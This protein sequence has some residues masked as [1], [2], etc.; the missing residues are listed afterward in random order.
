MADDD[1]TPSPDELEWTDEPPNPG[2]D[3]TPNPE[4]LDWSDTRPDE[5]EP[6]EQAGEEPPAA[7]RP[8]KPQAPISSGAEEPEEQ[9]AETGKTDILNL[10]SNVVSGAAKGFA[11]GIQEGSQVEPETPEEQQFRLK[12]PWI[13]GAVDLLNPGP[14]IRGVMGGIGGAIQG[15]VQAGAESLGATPGEAE[16]GAKEMTDLAMTFA[17]MHS[18]GIPHPPSPGGITKVDTIGSGDPAIRAA[19]AGEQPSPGPMVKEGPSTPPNQQAAEARQGGI[20]EPAN[21]NIP[22]ATAPAPAPLAETPSTGAVHPMNDLERTTAETQPAANENVPPRTEPA[23]TAGERVGQEIE[24]RENPENL[25]PFEPKSEK[26]GEGEVAGQNENEPAMTAGERLAQELEWKDNPEGLEEFKPKK[27]APDFDAE[28]ADIRKQ[29]ETAKGKERKALQEQLAA[30][31]NERDS[32]ALREAMPQRGRTGRPR[33]GG[34]RGGPEE[35]EGA[36]AMARNRMGKGKSPEDILKQIEEGGE[37]EKLEKANG[38]PKKNL[39]PPNLPTADAKWGEVP[40]KARWAL[41]KWF[42]KSPVGRLFVGEG[43]PEGEIASHDIRKFGR[44]YR[45]HDSIDHAL[46]GAEDVIG[47]LPTEAQREI[48]TFIDGTT[49]GS[50]INSMP[51]LQEH[52][53]AIRSQH[54]R[55]NDLVKQYGTMDLGDFDR[56]QWPRQFKDPEAAREYLDEW[57]AGGKT[58]DKR[59][60]TSNPRQDKTP[61][62][63]EMLDEGHELKNDNPI[64]ALRE[65]NRALYDKLALS[66]IIQAGKDRELIKDKPQEGWT[67]LKAKGLEG[68]TLYAP[69]GYASVFNRN[70]SPSLNDTA[71]GRALFKPLQKVGQLSTSINLGL[72]PFHF[73]TMMQERMVNQV[74]RALQG[75]SPLQTAASI[76]KILAGQGKQLME[77]WLDRGTHPELTKFIDKLEDIGAK[78]LGRHPELEMATEGEQAKWRYGT[79]TAAAKSGFRAVPDSWDRI[80]RDLKA[81]KEDIKLSDGALGK[82]RTIAAKTL[83]GVGE[84]MHLLTEPLFGVIIPR[85]K[86][87]SFHENLGRW[88]EKNPGYTDAQATKA[89]HEIWKDVESRF[90]LMNHDNLWIDRR[91]KEALTAGLTSMSWNY[92]FLRNAGLAMKDLGLHPQR[93]F[94]KSK[95]FNPNIHSV[96]GLALVAAMTG[97]A[98]GLYKTGQWPHNLFN[99]FF[100]PTGGDKNEHALTPGFQKDW[101]SYWLHPLDEPMNKLKPVWRSLYELGTNKGWMNTPGGPR[102]G[103][104]ADES[105]HSLADYMKEHAKHFLQQQTPISVQG[106][107]NA[108]PPGSKITPF[109]RFMA[110]RRAPKALTEGGGGGDEFKHRDWLKSHG[111]KETSEE[112][113]ARKKKTEDAL[114]TDQQGN[115]IKPNGDVIL[116]NGDVWH[117]DQG[118]VSAP[119]GHHKWN[120]GPNGERT[121]SRLYQIGPVVPQL[122]QNFRGGIPE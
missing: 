103:D 70:Y 6:V 66:N 67:K 119:G 52:I 35:V 57:R 93:A 113:T 92:G 116:K 51:E 115:K 39:T 8:F 117:K 33:T 53:D 99:A 62:L 84:T 73:S 78:P 79:N 5:E 111:I 36:Q 96:T 21:E 54:E 41:E 90:G 17:P 9:P 122:L 85:M 20:P 69:Q 48:R 1:D 32:A 28:I 71:L 47:K 45:N 68:Q 11:K 60:R 75:E 76:K 42:N 65:R 23:M 56:E 16:K 38:Q 25:E 112:K 29:L 87:S 89:A 63:E 72:S 94:M 49:P 61:G 88:M 12:H 7:E 4:D 2:T 110:I 26:L 86:I 104:I 27:A 50:K 19:M 40:T 120:A 24:A 3:E 102:Y 10:P 64:T 81:A 31:R 30:A 98:Y 114:P 55:T 74:A 118:T 77:E 15:G 59:G 43:T 121:G 97:T 46:E 107:I 83:N 44:F 91:I 106:Q 109:E 95:D 34:T 108:V 37:L 80:V 13:Q 58:K 105:K 18:T 82:T 101:T 22:Q 100:P 14:L